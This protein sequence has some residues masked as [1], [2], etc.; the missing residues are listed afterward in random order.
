MARLFVLV[1]LVGLLGPIALAQTADLTGTWD[2]QRLT[3]PNA[4]PAK[5]GV[6][7]LLP[8][9][10]YTLAPV[11]VRLG[12]AGDATVTLLTARPDGYEL[13]DVPSAYRAA[14]GRLGLSLGDVNTSWGLERQGDRLV[15]TA[16]DGVRL[17]LRRVADA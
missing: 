3:D 11:R 16:E 5:D 4:E 1:L 7:A 14:A 6:A 12:A 2:V 13:V 9:N 10:P 15:L 17:T 8:D